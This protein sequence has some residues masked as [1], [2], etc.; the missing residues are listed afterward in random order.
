MRVLERYA[1]YRACS[2]CINQ[3]TQWSRPEPSRSLTRVQ[4]VFCRSRYLW[5]DG[6]TF[7]N[8]KTLCKTAYSL[9]LLR[10]DNYLNSEKCEWRWLLTRFCLRK[11]QSGVALRTIET[12]LIIFASSL[13]RPGTAVDVC[14]SGLV[15]R[16][17]VGCCSQHGMKYIPT[18]R[19]MRH[20]FFCLQHG[21]V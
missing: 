5:R 13:K 9:F 3:P 21:G 4:T 14:F 16:F 1:Y 17:C 11:A 15:C 18:G 19:S 8:K 7:V 10:I 20:N 12:G 6:A 2:R